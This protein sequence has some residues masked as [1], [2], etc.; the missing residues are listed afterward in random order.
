MAQ[1]V[2]YIP[3]HHLPMRPVS[4]Q[5]EVSSVLLLY[6]QELAFL[7][8]VWLSQQTAA[9]LLWGFVYF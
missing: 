5:R 2:L 9:F 1:T 3:K 7:T 6:V 4:G 8:S